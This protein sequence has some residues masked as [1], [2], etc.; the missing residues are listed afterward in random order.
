[1]TS[2]SAA[3]AI[4]GGVPV[5]RTTLLLT[6][7]AVLGVATAALPEVR[8]L[9]GHAVDGDG[10][11]VRAEL[12]GLGAWAAVV[13]VGAILLHNVVP[14]PAE[15]LTAAGGYALGIAVGLPV[16]AAAWL[17][18]A[19]V[20]Y[21]L[22]MDAGRPLAQK[23]AG[24]R[25]VDRLEQAIARGGV[26]ALLLLRLV[27]LVPFTLAS[28]VAGVARVPVGRFAWTSLVGF[29]PMTTLCVV[30]G[31][32]LQEPSLTDP[33]LWGP[34]AGLVLLV[35]VTPALSRRLGSAAA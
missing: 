8:D 4:L 26:R 5:R 29:L 23:M 6:L 15:L 14:I 27:P 7:M 24:A 31:A 19:L 10:E 2:R 32:R 25:R 1:M 18:S 28:V 12:D 9:V 11:A 3:S 34:L 30:L 21:W 22:G 33:L 20:G 35:L 13:L 16:L 17:G